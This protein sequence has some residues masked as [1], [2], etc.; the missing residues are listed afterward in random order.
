MDLFKKE[1]VPIIM[2]I[3]RRMTKLNLL[4]VFA[5]FWLQTPLSHALPLPTPGE[6]TIKQVSSQKIL[7]VH[8]TFGDGHISNSV[9]KLVQYYLL[10]ANDNY[11]VVFPQMSIERSD[12]QGSYVAIGYKG[13]P[14]ETDIVKTMEL[15]G[16]LVA[17][18]IYKGSYTQIGKAIRGV[19]RR[20]V[21][22]HKYIPAAN[23][24]IRLLY[25]NS[26]DDNQPE[27]LITE[28]Q[29]RIEK[30]GSFR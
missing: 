21:D 6:F 2:N 5:I 7:Y 20:A 25:W 27:N 4:F 14:A 9:V 30:L 23:G 24:E 11:Q 17:S 1:M 8:H 26:I 12:I 13:N 29:V 3:D 16:G 18:Y 22:T 19:F 10:N 15:K 28:I